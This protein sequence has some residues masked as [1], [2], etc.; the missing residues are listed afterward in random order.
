MH[1]LEI[2]AEEERQAKL[3][4]DVRERSSEIRKA[5]AQA[6]LDN[7]RRREPVVDDYNALTSQAN[8]QTTEFERTPADEVALEKLSQRFCQAIDDMDDTVNRPAHYAQQGQIECIDVLEQLAE[9]GHDFRILNAMKYLWRYRHKGG[10]ESLQKAQWY[11]D[12]VL[13]F[14]NDE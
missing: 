6:A 13:E 2:E 10:Y 8:R 3:A 5:R 11:I 14:P 12:R 9:D 4:S 7:L 1:H